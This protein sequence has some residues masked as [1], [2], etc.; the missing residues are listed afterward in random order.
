MAATGVQVVLPSQLLCAKLHGPLGDRSNVHMARINGILLRV[1]TQLLPCAP[2]PVEIVGGLGAGVLSPV[3]FPYEF[4]HIIR[5][6]SW[7]DG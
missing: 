3:L 5:V 4:T 6:I 2:L 1:R 7:W